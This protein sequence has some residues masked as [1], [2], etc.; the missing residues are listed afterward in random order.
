MLIKE[1]VLAQRNGWK[2]RGVKGKGE[3]HNQVFTSSTL[4]I[5]L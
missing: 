5:F 3:T 4:A 1:K 2:D